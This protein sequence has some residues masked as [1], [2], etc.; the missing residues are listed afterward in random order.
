MKKT[1]PILY[2]KKSFKDSRGEF[3]E[4]YN[5]KFMLKNFELKEKFKQDNISISNKGVI[6]G[7]HYQSKKPQGKLISVLSGSIYD[8]IVDIRPYSN[9]FLK[10]F[11]YRLDSIKSES[12]WVPPGF[13]HGFQALSRNTIVHYKCNNYYSPETEYTIL[14]SDPDLNIKWP[15]KPTKISK[16]DLLGKSLKQLF[17]L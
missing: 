4:L 12:L 17:S 3:Y 10:K 6:R 5:E 2:K 16:K 15:L 9:D 13:A 11:I 8:V 1:K 14:W 7:L